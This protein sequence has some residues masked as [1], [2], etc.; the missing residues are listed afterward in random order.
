MG[1]WEVLEDDDVA[2]TPYVLEVEMRQPWWAVFH[3]ESG[4]TYEAFFEDEAWWICT[5]PGEP[6]DGPFETVDD[7]TNWLEN[8]GQ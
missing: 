1:D 2:E 4:D 7:V 6:S 8:G 3:C 5:T